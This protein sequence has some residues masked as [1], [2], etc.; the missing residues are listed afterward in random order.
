L[1][2]LTGISET[3]KFVEKLKNGGGNLGFVATMGSLHD[4]H[5]SLVNQS[6]EKN[7]FTAVSIFVNPTQF[8]ENKDFKSYPRDLQSDLDIL[9]PLPVDLVFAPSESEIYPE[10]DT[11]KFDF[12]GL[13]KVMEGKHR[14]GHFNGVAQVVSKLFNILKPDRAY[15]GEKDYQQLAII[16]KITRDLQLPVEII[17]CPIIRESDGLAMSSRNRLLNDKE[18]ESAANISR[19]LFSASDRAG[20]LSPGELIRNTILDLDSDHLIETE[21]FDIVDSESLRSISD[22]SYPGPIRGCIAA[23][24]GHVRL[25]DNM[26]FSC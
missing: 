18:R 26:D 23:K 6:L 2:L 19:A 24:I 16:R 13:D 12:G 20:S 8:N 5:I 17:A 21:Y 7:S 10:P 9:K 1:K 25:I 22:W 14:P 3:L 4:G 11:R 15:F